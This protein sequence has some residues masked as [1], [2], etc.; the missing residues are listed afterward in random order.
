M[1]EDFHWNIKT[2]KHDIFICKIGL[3]E[4]RSIKSH[5]RWIDIDEFNVASEKELF[6]FFESEWKSVN[7]AEDF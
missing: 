1:T 7:D 3:S 2:F 6:I 4:S 5:R